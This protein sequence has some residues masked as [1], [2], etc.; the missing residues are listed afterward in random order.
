MSAW[1]MVKK[2]T[3]TS[4]WRFGLWVT[5]NR[6]GLWKWHCT[7]YLSSIERHVYT[8]IYTKIH[9]CSGFD[10]CIG[11][12]ILLPWRLLWHLGNLQHQRLTCFTNRMPVG[13]RADQR[14]FL[15]RKTNEGLILQ[16]WIYHH[17]KWGEKSGM[18]LIKHG[19]HAERPTPFILFPLSGP[20][21]QARNLELVTQPNGPSASAIL[22]MNSPFEIRMD[23]PWKINFLPH[24]CHVWQFR[25]GFLVCNHLQ[26]IPPNP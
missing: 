11:G 19:N 16:T 13:C 4:W 2:E 5:T 21:F 7:S 17:Q 3:K 24:S 20:N 18:F 22:R 9:T 10:T 1:R 26:S 25:W 8:C 14:E 6:D 15:Q 23:T 12:A